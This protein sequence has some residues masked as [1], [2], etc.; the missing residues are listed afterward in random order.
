MFCIILFGNADLFGIC[1][2][3]ALIWCRLLC[4]GFVV[5]VCSHVA[6]FAL[7]GLVVCMPS[8]GAVC[9]VGFCVS[10]CSYLALLA[11]FGLAGFACS[12]LALV[13]L[14]GLC[15]FVFSYVALFAVLG[16][17]VL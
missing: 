5:S 1:G 6:L 3:Y 9:V 16:F 17:V 7:S 8:F 11:L 2:S 4:L 14:F 12:C 15:N 10:A 13:A